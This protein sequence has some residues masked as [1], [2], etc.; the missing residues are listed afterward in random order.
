MARKA[1]VEFAGA[2]YHLLDRGDRRE[3]VFKDD[4]GRRRFLET[5]GGK[6]AGQSVNLAPENGER[7][8][9]AVVR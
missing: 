4:V 6:G 8:G 5:L 2:I 9:V 1:R 3:A 7:R